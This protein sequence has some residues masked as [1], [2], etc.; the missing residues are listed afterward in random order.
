R[1]EQDQW[2]QHDS[3]S[4]INILAASGIIHG[5]IFD[6]FV[7]IEN[8]PLDE[9]L[10]SIS[11]D[12]RVSSFSFDECSHYN[13]SLTVNLVE[14]IELFLTA[15]PAVFDEKAVDLLG[16]RLR[17]TA[18]FFIQNSSRK[19]NELSWE[20]DADRQTVDNLN[21]GKFDYPQNTTLGASFEKQALETPD[22]TALVFG[23]LFFTY[24]ELNNRV[25]RQAAKF[26]CQQFAHD[27]LVALCVERHADMIIAILAVLKAG[28][29]YVPISPDVP[30]SR[31][32]YLL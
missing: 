22:A 29:A 9:S 18:E 13:I 30:Q 14:D 8:Y 1:E 2:M 28:M 20:S 6:T 32:D 5:E 26:A 11:N 7:A 21:K 23:D 16:D 24:R 17:K 10:R 3:A 15:N 12:L 19:F 4:L 31:L 25:D 27:T